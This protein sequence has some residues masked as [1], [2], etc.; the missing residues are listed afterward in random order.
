MKALDGRVLELTLG[1]S[2]EASVV[3]LMPPSEILIRVGG[4]QDSPS[5]RLLRIRND[6]VR[7]L[8]SFSIGETIELRVVELLPLRFQLQTQF[9][10]QENRRRGR[11]D[12][13]V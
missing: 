10:S 13:S 11:I 12:V 4:L 8:S 7:P 3:E 6:T 2:I 1:Q 9:Q 5:A